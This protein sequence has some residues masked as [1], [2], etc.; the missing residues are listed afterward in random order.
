M[1][2]LYNIHEI[3]N[4]YLWLLSHCESHESCDSQCL[5]FE[6]PNLWLNCDA[7]RDSQHGP[8]MQFA[9][10]RG[11]IQATFQ[12]W[13]YSG[14]VPEVCKTVACKRW[15]EFG[16]ESKFPHPMSTSSK[17]QCCFCF[18]LTF[19]SILDQP[20]LWGPDMTTQMIRKRFFCVADVCVMGKSIPRQL[21]RITVAFT[22][23]VLWRRPS[24]TKKACQKALCDKCPVQLGSNITSPKL[25][26]L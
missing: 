3:N 20:L 23:S 16:P 7:V 22:E 13:I 14:R 5:L 18:Y 4:L 19:V 11:S 25:K 24:Y 1:P 17:P 6:S 2:S 9:K 10:Q 15:F 12:K 8:K 21:M 26:S